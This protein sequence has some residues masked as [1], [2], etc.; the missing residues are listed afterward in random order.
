MNEYFTLIERI[1]DEW[2]VKNHLITFFNNNNVSI[3]IDRKVKDISQEVKMSPE[4]KLAYDSICSTLKSTQSL[5]IYRISG[6]CIQFN[7][8]DSRTSSSDLM[9]VS[10]YGDGRV[11]LP[12]LRGIKRQ[13]V[14]E[15]PF[16]TDDINWFKRII[17]IDNNYTTSNRPGQPSKEEFDI[18]HDK[19]QTELR[20]IYK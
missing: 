4:Q 3:V 1:K 7:K 11:K 16:T 5:Q 17:W 19:D 2:T 12:I 8:F 14:T 15:L 10:I 6:S 13:S 18:L 9:W 20:E